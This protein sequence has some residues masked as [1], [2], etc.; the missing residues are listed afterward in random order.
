[1]HLFLPRVTVCHSALRSLPGA[2]LGPVHTYVTLR[3]PSH[4]LLPSVDGVSGQCARFPG[5]REEGPGS[6]LASWGPVSGGHRVLHG[7]ASCLDQ[8]K[9]NPYLR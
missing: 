4:L 1:M 7:E 9:Q 3:V 2:G 5:L 6:G 8:D